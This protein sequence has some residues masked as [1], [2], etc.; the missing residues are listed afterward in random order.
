MQRS[1]LWPAVAALLL[2]PL[3]DSQQVQHGR[4][5]EELRSIS[6]AVQATRTG[7]QAVDENCFQLPAESY[8][9]GTGPVAFWKF[10]G[11]LGTLRRIIVLLRVSGSSSVCFQNFAV[12][13]EVELSTGSQAALLL[14][15]GAGLPDAPFLAWSGESR[16][17]VLEGFTSLQCPPTYAGPSAA[18]LSSSG[19][20]SERVVFER[21][22]ALDF[23]FYTSPPGQ[24]ETITGT[25]EVGPFGA[26]FGAADCA[27][28]WIEESEG[29][30]WSMA[31]VTYVYEPR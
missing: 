26:S 27:D 4:A 28:G 8:S 9:V 3:T 6:T 15:R 10:P 16:S 25:L 18:C 31:R 17:F 23:D 2:S 22:G 21:G 5:P 30:A 19:T 1:L 11:E 7:I 24:S 12:P 13:C 14:P 20:A 29:S